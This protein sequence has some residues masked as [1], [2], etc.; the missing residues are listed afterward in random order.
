MQMTLNGIAQGFITDHISNILKNAGY[1]HVLIEL[2]E[3]RAIGPHPELRPWSIGIKDAQ[4]PAKLH[5][6]AELDNQALA[7]S[8]SYGSP[9]SKDGNFHHL[10]FFSRQIYRIIQFTKDLYNF[11]SSRQW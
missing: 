2:G 11:S 10:I 4:Q 5:E 3:T 1:Q 9:F 6:V 8:G 7:T